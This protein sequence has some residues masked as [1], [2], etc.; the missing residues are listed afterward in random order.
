MSS[1]VHD[2][3]KSDDSI[4]ASGKV[5]NDV[6]MSYVSWHNTLFVAVHI[7]FLDLQFH[8]RPFDRHFQVHRRYCI[9]SQGSHYHLSDSHALMSLDP[10]TTLINKSDTGVKV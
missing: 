7:G 4:W 10:C 2:V 1:Y 8:F 9:S 3:T 6:P 5:V